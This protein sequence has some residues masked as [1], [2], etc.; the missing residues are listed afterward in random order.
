M[1]PHSVVMKIINIADD[2]DDDV[3]VIYE[4]PKTSKSKGAK[5]SDA[6]EKRN[7]QVSLFKIL[8]SKPSC[9]GTKKAF[10]DL[11]KESPDEEI[12]ILDSNFSFSKNSKRGSNSKSIVID[13]DGNDNFTCDICVDEKSMSEMFK[14]MGCTHSYC[15]QCMAKYV[16][17]KLQENISRISCP[18][19]GCNGLLEPY[20]CHSILPNEVFNRWGD[21]LCEK[22]ILGYEKFYCPFKDCSALLIDE[23]SGENIVITQS[24]C[25]ECK[26]LFCAKCKVPWHL[27]IVCE[28][29]E[30]LHKDERE[31]ED[32]QLMQLAKSQ[33]WQRCPNCRYYVA[34]SQG[35]AQMHCRCGC[36]FCYK[37]GAQS[38]N[39]YCSNCGT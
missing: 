17:S 24:K 33:E 7:Q 35:C 5:I 16:A 3:S 27:G 38:T 8:C 28:E 26:R 4:T 34:R 18:V 32:I 21:A 20:Y 1:N 13:D 6:I 30:K 14:I 11:S 22:V 2:N 9:S 19:S 15:K 23:C 39:H 37:C 10:I 36:D 31:R 29:F 25:P 12:Q